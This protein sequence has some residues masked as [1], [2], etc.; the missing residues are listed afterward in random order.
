MKKRFFAVLACLLLL[1]TV[2]CQKDAGGADTKLDNESLKDKLDK[3][4]NTDPQPL[5][6]IE[7]SVMYL[8][9]NTGLTSYDTGAFEQAEEL[10]ADF[11][12]AKTLALSALPVSIR[13]IETQDLAVYVDFD[14]EYFLS[15]ENTEKNEAS[16][17]YSIR[18]SLLRNSDAI[19]TVY[20]TLDGGD[21]VTDFHAFSAS[22]PFVPDILEAPYPDVQTV[23]YQIVCYDVVE[24]REF[25]YSGNYRY[26]ETLDPFYFIEKLSVL[27]DITIAVNSVTVNDGIITV[28]CSSNGAPCNGLGSYEES[29]LLE[30]L[31]SLLLQV[32]P[33]AD[34]VCLSQDGS[35]YNSGH[36]LSERTTPYATRTPKLLG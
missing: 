12:V 34:A 11:I 26:I 10:T 27:S 23:D 35:D 22:T 21:F 4:L 18:H 30:S 6:T 15:D 13:S 36:I 24:D 14:S 1:S 2:S 29:R 19:E 3:V 17:L 31:C 9:R 5:R 32:Y 7:Y 28:D 33:E 25:T 8:D 20:Y 16:L